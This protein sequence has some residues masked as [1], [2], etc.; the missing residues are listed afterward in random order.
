M[1]KDLVPPDFHP[2]QDVENFLAAK[3]TECASCQLPILPS[4]N[5]SAKEAIQR[6]CAPVLRRPDYYIIP[7]IH[8]KVAKDGSCLVQDLVV[9]RYAYGN[10]MFPG[11]TDVAGMDLDSIL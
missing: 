6:S 10:V 8:D 7:P 9:G 4:C 3:Q 5:Y 2:L 11:E 1:D